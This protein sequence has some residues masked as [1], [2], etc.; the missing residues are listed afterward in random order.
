LTEKRLDIHASRFSIS[1]IEGWDSMF[2]G[3]SGLSGSGVSS[4]PMATKRK[5][6]RRQE[7]L[8]GYLF[9]LPGLLGLILFSAIPLGAALYLSFTN[10]NIL[11][12]PEWVGFKNYSY[13]FN[14]DDLFWPSLRRTFYFVLLDVPLGM[15]LSMAL[16]LLLNQK[17]K[18]TALFR[19]LFFLPSITPAVAAIFFWVWLLNPYFG[20]VNYALGKIGILGPLWFQGTDSAMPSIALISLWAGAGGTRMIILLAGLQGIPQDL[21]DAAEVDGAGTWRKFRNIT[22]PMLTPTLFFVSVLSVISALKVFTSVYIGT[23][24]GPAYAT[25][26]FSYHLFKQ[27][28]QFFEM[29]YASALGWI[30]FLIIMVF[31]VVQFGFQSRWVHY[32]DGKS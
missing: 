18:G 12:P 23:E 21:Y 11:Q 3:L 7:E 24:G 10:Y 19:T 9:I 8:F 4:K 6:L 15:V 28:F 31:T 26:V 14:G 27:A 20:I 25:W 2:S 5:S 13:A 17:L 32:E 29:G 16:A 22:L 1:V 30:F